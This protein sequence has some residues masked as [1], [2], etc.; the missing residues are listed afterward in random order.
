MYC[1]PWQIYLQYEFKILCNYSVFSC[2]ARQGPVTIQGTLDMCKEMTFSWKVMAQG[3]QYWAVRWWEELHKEWQCWTESSTWAMPTKAV[4]VLSSPA[5]TLVAIEVEAEIL[6]SL[7][8][9]TNSNWRFAKSTPWEHSPLKWKYALSPLLLKFNQKQ[10]CFN[11]LKL[12]PKV[13]RQRRKSW[14]SS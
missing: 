7:L 9:H 14:K 13:F 2:R 4:L 5:V 8:R 6:G 10:T 12:T 11:N 1:L 3:C